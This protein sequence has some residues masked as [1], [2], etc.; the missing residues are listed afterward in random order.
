MGEKDS[1][2][3]GGEAKKGGGGGDGGSIAVVLK[4]DMH[5]EGCAKKVRKTVKTFQGVE[6]V[7]VNS[8]T[9]KLT[10]KGKVD[11]A[12]LRERVE[13]KTKKKVELVS[14]QVKKDGGEKKTEEKS[15]EKKAGDDK[16]KKKE[17]QVT[18]LVM[19]IPLHCEGCI[20]KIRKIITK[21]KE[22]QSVTI[23]ASKD[24]VTIKGTMDPKSFLP[25]LKEK[26][27]RSVDVVPP[28]P[29][30]GTDKKPADADAKKGKAPAAAAGGG[31][32]EKEKS[33]GGGGGGDGGGAKKGE[34]KVESNRMEYYSP[35]YGFEYGPGPGPGHVLVQPGPF[36]GYGLG[37][38]PGAA[39]PVHGYGPGMGGPVH[40]YGNGYMVEYAHTHAHAPQMFSDENPNACS[41]M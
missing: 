22:V 5:C 31:D 6:S 15:S 16:E 24:L 13:H 12:K 34:T 4:L 30:D 27:K 23:D 1:K 2:S 19:K 36:H 18:T 9:N 26:L 28:K 17:P 20:K 3:E 39:G 8:E 40:G 7:E 21:Y 35:G 32:G 29:A 41:V 11:P 14:P 10:V 33:G 37:Y 38:G 25:T